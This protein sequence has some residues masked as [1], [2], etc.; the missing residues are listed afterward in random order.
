MLN[1][2]KNAFKCRQDVLTH[3]DSV[4]GR[5]KQRLG[6]LYCCRSLLGN[7]GIA[8]ACKSWI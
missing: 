2:Q 6:Q 3:I 4:L 8:T 7:Q 5:E 1:Y